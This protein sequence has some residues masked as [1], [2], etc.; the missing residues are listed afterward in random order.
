MVQEDLAL[1]DPDVLLAAVDLKFKKQ[2]RWAWASLLA[3]GTVLTLQPWFE[4]RWFS[5]VILIAGLMLCVLE[6]IPSSGEGFVAMML[7]HRKSKQ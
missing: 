5:L 7:R 1:I 6:F 3:V 2:R 4:I